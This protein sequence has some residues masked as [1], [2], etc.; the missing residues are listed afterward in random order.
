MS[1]SSS[2]KSPDQPEKITKKNL[3]KAVSNYIANELG[4]TRTVIEQIIAEKVARH[5]IGLFIRK[6]LNQYFKKSDPNRPGSRMTVTAR[7]HV[8]DALD[9]E[10]QKALDSG[11]S[12]EIQEI[13]NAHVKEIIGRERVR[14]KTMAEIS[15]ETRVNDLFDFGF[16]V[17]TDSAV[18]SMYNPDV[19]AHSEVYGCYTCNGPAIPVAEVFLTRDNNIVVSYKLP[20]IQDNIKAMENIEKA[21]IAMREAINAANLH[22]AVTGGS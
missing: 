21:K 19:V 20:D 2:K 13:V 1:L 10:I 8:Y 22:K 9:K 7:N 17:D 5:D 18:V 3:Y 11:V 15:A 14:D 4:L 6:E 12:H 16:S